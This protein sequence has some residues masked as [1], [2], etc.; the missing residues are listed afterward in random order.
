MLC[1][2]VASYKISKF[3]TSSYASSAIKS[4]VKHLDDFM[5]LLAS[6]TLMRALVMSDMRML[7]K[8]PMKKEATMQY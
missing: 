8:N 6:R 4:F 1:S 7:P 5:N 2:L 3:L